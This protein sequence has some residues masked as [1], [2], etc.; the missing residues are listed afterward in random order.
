VR[1]LARGVRAYLWATY[2]AAVVLVGG[3]GATLVEWDP[4][5][6]AHRALWPA[7]AVFTALAY[8]VERQVLPVTPAVWWSLDSA[9]YLAAIL[10][11]PWPLPVAVVLPAAL[12][13]RGWPRAPRRQ[14]ARHKRAFNVA[15]ALLTVGLVALCGR[16]VLP[17]AAPRPGHLAGAVPALLALGALYYALDVGPLL[18][19]HTLQ[20]GRAPWR[21]WAEHQRPAA[22]LAM[23]D[24]AL[25]VVAALAWRTDPLALGLLALPLLVRGA[26]VQAGAAAAEGRA[27]AAEGRAAAARA[28]AAT[29]GL[30][31]LLN[32]RAFQDRLAGE[33]ARAGR[34]GQPVALLMVDLDDFGAINN[35]HGHQVGDAVLGAVAQALCV[36]VRAGDVPA[37]YG[38]DEFV[39]ILPRTAVGEAVAIAR[40]VQAVVVE[41]TPAAGRARPR[42]G[43]SVGIAV[44]PGHADSCEELIRAADDAAYAA[45]GAGKGNVQVA[46]GP[47]AGGA[48]L[49]A[50]PR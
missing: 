12:L 34:E 4:F 17:A 36:E 46:A 43:A 42:V 10:T 49:P 13:A 7:V 39:V 26:G 50:P 18:V 11:V 44:L 25:G 16:L 41:A 30:T 23:A 22:P 14:L 27:A 37:R 21:L 19:V 48:P 29:D 47:D 2:L 28:A 15:H 40:R 5:A 32:H 24:L 3:A 33:V 6:P 38:G 31:G 9:F 35:A 45:K 1:E 20:T 8:L